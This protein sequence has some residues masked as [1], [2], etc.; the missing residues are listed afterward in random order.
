MQLMESTTVFEHKLYII[1]NF[2]KFLKQTL[3]ILFQL[4]NAEMKFEN[5]VT[6][7]LTNKLSLFFLFYKDF[8]SWA[9]SIPDMIDLIN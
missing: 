9:R 3:F 1:S 7:S 4:F 5:C 8:W 6:C 2:I